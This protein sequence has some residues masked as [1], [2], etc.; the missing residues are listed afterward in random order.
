MATFVDVGIEYVAKLINGVS[1][2]PFIYMALGSSPGL[3]GD[4]Q[5]QLFSERTSY[6]LERK[7]VVCSYEAPGKATWS[8]EFDCTTD[9]IYVNEVGIF[10]DASAGHMLVRH[11]Y[12]SQKILDAGDKMTVSV[13]FT[14]TRS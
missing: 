9:G 3:E 10:D 2:S 7:E 8:G 5:T 4:D 11:R 1:T 14:E 6:G 12:V 13:V